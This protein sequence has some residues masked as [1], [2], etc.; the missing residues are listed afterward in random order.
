[1][2][3]QKIHMEFN[4]AD[5][6]FLL[7]RLEFSWAEFIIFLLSCGLAAVLLRFLP[8]NLLIRILLAGGVLILGFVFVYIKPLGRSMLKWVGDILNYSLE[9]KTR[10][11]TKTD[12]YPA[13]Q[14]DLGIL[15]ISDSVAKTDTGAYIALLELQGLHVATMSFDERESLAYRFTQFLNTLTFPIQFLVRLRRISFEGYLGKLEELVST[16]TNPFILT[17]LVSFGDFILEKTADRNLI[18]RQY[19]LVIPY[20]PAP[21]S[22]GKAGPKGA[23]AAIRNLF[24]PK[25]QK[26]TDTAELLEEDAKTALYERCVLISRSLSRVGV[27]SR[28]LVSDE[29][30]EVFYSTNNPQL[31]ERQPWRIDGALAEAYF[32]HH[33]K[34]LERGERFF[35]ERIENSLPQEDAAAKPPQDDTLYI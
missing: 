4:E 8:G 7:H 27:Y 25:A 35:A 21:M 17:Y 2:A 24:F 19:Y 32:P 22:L 9:T 5:K 13:T 33:A 23:F 12:D 16:A 10:V 20:V 15:S 18:S 14:D 30:K 28:R 34:E 29:M 3:R 31:S 1:M 6:I 11:W 26:D